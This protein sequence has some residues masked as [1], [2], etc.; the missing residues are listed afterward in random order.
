MPASSDQALSGGAAIIIDTFLPAFL[1]G[2]VVFVFMAIGEDESKKVIY[3]ACPFGVVS[4]KT[5]DLVVLRQRLTDLAER[6]HDCTLGDG[7]LDE[8]A[9]WE[10]ASEELHKVIARLKRIERTRERTK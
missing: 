1:M 9:Q 7:P 8:N 10:S 5:E 6:F 2:T 4:Y 3:L